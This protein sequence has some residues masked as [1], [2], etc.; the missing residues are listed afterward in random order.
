MFPTDP[1]MRRKRKSEKDYER[2]EKK[3]RITKKAEMQAN[4]QNVQPE[5]IKCLDFGAMKNACKRLVSKKKGSFDFKENQGN[6]SNAKGSSGLGRVLT[7]I[8]EQNVFSNPNSELKPAHSK[9]SAPNAQPSTSS[10]AE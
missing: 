10:T 1:L 3:A 2:E 9:E 7:E 4:V 5:V 6:T 8:G